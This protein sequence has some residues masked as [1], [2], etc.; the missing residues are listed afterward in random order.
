MSFPKLL[1][2]T[3]QFGWNIQE[4]T[5]FELLDAFYESGFRQ[6][7]C[8]TN[9]PI[10]KN[11]DDFRAAENI[12]KTW[13]FAH[14]I[15]DLEVMMKVGSLNNLKTSDSNTSRSFL[16]MSLENCRNVF[17]ENLDT[18]MIHWDNSEDENQINETLNALKTAQNEGLKVGLSGIKNP[19]IYSE[20]NQKY[21][22]DFFIQVKN[23]ILQSDLERYIDFFPKE[24]YIAYGINAGGIKLNTDEYAEKSTLAIRGGDISNQNE[25]FEDL[26]RR[27]NLA[28]ENKNRPAIHSFFQLG[29][30]HS[31]YNPLI[32][33]I[34]IGN[35][36]VS[37]WKSTFDFYQDLQNYDYK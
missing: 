37:Q 16:L 20:V 5:A 26:K 18:L 12:L 31:F 17:R 23:N 1:L 25:I 14:G 35:S 4:K 13:L 10:N 21:N 19:K 36:S 32:S 29:M 24:K 11:P 30:I 22:L 27:I 33:G 6:V 28:N 2:G 3:A 15:K 34:L 8:A 7:D 9:Y